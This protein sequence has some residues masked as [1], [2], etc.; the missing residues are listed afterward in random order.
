MFAG[1]IGDHAVH[2]GPRGVNRVDVHRDS[3]VWIIRETESHRGT[4]GDTDS[5]ANSRRCESILEFVDEC[6]RPCGR[7]SQPVDHA[8]LRERWSIMMFSF[9]SRS[10]VAALARFLSEG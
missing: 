6:P 2:I 1:H 8:R 10:G 9:L 7:Q 3:E 5:G 4:A